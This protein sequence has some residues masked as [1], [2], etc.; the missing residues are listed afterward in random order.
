M[1][2]R[3]PIDEFWFNRCFRESSLRNYKKSSTLSIQNL[4]ALSPAVRS[5]IIYTLFVEIPS[6]LEIPP[7]AGFLWNFAQQKTIKGRIRFRT[8]TIV[9]S[10]SRDI[11]SD[12]PKS[13]I[14]IK[15]RLCVIHVLSIFKI[16]INLFRYK[17]F[18]NR[19][20]TCKNTRSS[21][22]QGFWYWDT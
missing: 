14:I 19:R 17:R 15:L 20:C 12:R 4:S 6:Y 5:C 3:K 21:H 9:T 13:N 10:L 1:F 8:K 22:L 2:K 7:I 18:K 16:K 11:H